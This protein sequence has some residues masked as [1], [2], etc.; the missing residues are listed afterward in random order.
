MTW[1]EG[2]S[3][4]AAE[5]WSS[6]WWCF[7]FCVMPPFCGVSLL[8]DS[9]MIASMRVD[10]AKRHTVAIAVA[11]GVSTF[12]L[13]IA[14][15]VFGIDRSELGVPWYR[16]RVCAEEP[17]AVATASGFTINAPYGL[18]TLARADTIVVTP[19]GAGWEPSEALLKTLA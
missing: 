13:G 12:E 10:P 5:V 4:R 8:S 17:G 1:G 19:P 11:P 3:L 15:E 7:G 18:D 9:G 6:E 14:C 2:A 16:L